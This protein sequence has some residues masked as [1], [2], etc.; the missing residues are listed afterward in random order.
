MLSYEDGVSAMEWLRDIFGMDIKEK[1]LGEDGRLEH[2]ELEYSGQRIMLATP[3]PL[4]QSP[5]TLRKNYPLPW[6]LRR[7]H[8]SWM[9]FSFTSRM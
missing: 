5:K 4:Y 8:T 6:S 1:W 2:G 3:T 9:E 7:F